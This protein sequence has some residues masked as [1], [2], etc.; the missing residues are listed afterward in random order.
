MQPV[1][2]KIINVSSVLIIERMSI[3]EDK[4]SE[5][6]DETRSR[7]TVSKQFKDKVVKPI[8]KVHENQFFESKPHKFRHFQRHFRRDEFLGRINEMVYFLP[9]SKSEINK[10]ILKEL[11]FWKKRVRSLCSTIIG[12]I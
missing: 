3:G 7:I 12:H 2:T 5:H 8:L 9:F 4:P 10:L 1:R 11:E 6:E